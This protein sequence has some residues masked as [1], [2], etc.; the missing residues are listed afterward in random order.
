MKYFIGFTIFFGIYG[1]KVKR[2]KINFNVKT[3]RLEILERL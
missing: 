3:T 1:N 2:S